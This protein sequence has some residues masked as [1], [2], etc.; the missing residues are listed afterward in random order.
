MPYIQLLNAMIGYKVTS[1]SMC[2]NG[3]FITLSSQNLITAFT[4]FG[5]RI[6]KKT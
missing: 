3:S 4:K 1:G 5:I 2:A 6:F